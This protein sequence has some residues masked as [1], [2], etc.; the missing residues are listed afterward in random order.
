[1]RLCLREVIGSN[2][3]VSSVRGAGGIVTVST[4]SPAPG[5]DTPFADKWEMTVLPV[6]RNC[7]ARIDVALVSDRQ[8][9]PFPGPPVREGETVAVWVVSFRAEDCLQRSRQSFPVLP[10][11]MMRHFPGLTGSSGVPWRLQR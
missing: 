5:T 7:S 4:A 3:P 8:P 1:M 11:G 2:L 10:I 9:N 6:P